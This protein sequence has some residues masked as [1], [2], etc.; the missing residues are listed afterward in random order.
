MIRSAPKRLLQALADLTGSSANI[1]F[2]SGTCAQKFAGVQTRAVHFADSQR[3]GSADSQ[4][5]GSVNKS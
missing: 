3:N 2:D 1:C 4:R 5:K